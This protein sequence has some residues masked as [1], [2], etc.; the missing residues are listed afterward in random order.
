MHILADILATSSLIL[1]NFESFWFTITSRNDNRPVS[2]GNA[3]IAP[4]IWADI[5]LSILSA[6]P[7]FESI[8]FFK[9]RLNRGKYP[10][11]LTGD[12]ASAIWQAKPSE[13]FTR[14]SA[15]S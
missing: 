14:Y 15:L 10:T 6:L 11:N 3:S 8:I 7:K 1:E 4:D 13:D 12:G 2:Y 5:M 9:Q